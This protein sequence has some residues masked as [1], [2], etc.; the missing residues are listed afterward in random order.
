MEGEERP[1]GAG[2]HEG[3]AEG[4]RETYGARLEPE[5][6]G[7]ERLVGGE[8]GGGAGTEAGDAVIEGRRFSAQ[9]FEDFVAA[10]RIGDEDGGGHASANG[11]F[12]ALSHLWGHVFAGRI[13]AEPF[14][15]GNENRGGFNGRSGHG[16]EVV[17]G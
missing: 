17:A 5:G 12:E 15:V 3:N 10:A 4:D 6:S 1:E 9:S 13:D 14:G 16:A 8:G 2:E 7:R 11:L